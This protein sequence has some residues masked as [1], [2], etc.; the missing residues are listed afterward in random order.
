MS[1]SLASVLTLLAVALAATP[2]ATATAVAATPK[3]GSF[4]GA[5]GVTVPKGAAAEVR[6]IDRVTGAVAGTASVSRTGAFT[7]RLP[8]G[9]YTVIGTVL[10]KKGPAT[11]IVSAVSLKAG[12]KRTKADLKHSKRTK[13]KSKTKKKAKASYVQELGQVTPGTVAAGIHAFTGN[14]TGEW[15]NVQKGLQSLLSASVAEAVAKCPVAIVE[16]ERRADILKELE[17][18]KSKYVDPSTRVTRNFI[19]ED[20]QVSGSV[21]QVDADHAV[22]TA[23]I[24]DNKTGKA[25]AQ[26]TENVDADHVFEK[27]QDF[28]DNIGKELCTLHDTYDVTLNL[29]ANGN[30]ATHAATGAFS[31]TLL[32]KRTSAPGVVPVVST[33][34]A[35][36][37]WTGLTCTMKIGSTLCYALIAPAVA[38]HAT[39]NTTKDALQVQWEI[40]GKDLATG[41]FDVQPSGPDDPDPPPVPGVGLVYSIG[42]APQ[43]F[44]LP[45]AGGTQAISGAVTEG[46][47]GFTTTGTITVTPVGYTAEP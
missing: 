28:A 21:V 20:V 42:A 1:R 33:A 35:P 22:V 30:F 25:I 3:P 38:W 31:G 32:A 13:V 12:Q 47:D 4:S 36:F 7:L 39:I 26:V 17:F 5:L 11:R 43:S 9:A 29:N 23:T 37:A 8:A 41:T 14:A 18:Q 44:T 24:T 2:A 40:D 15:A 46:G 27:L 10:P 34:S 19:V 16:I 6:A 45:Y